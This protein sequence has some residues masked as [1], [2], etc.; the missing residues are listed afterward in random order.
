MLLSKECQN[1]IFLTQDFSNFFHSKSNKTKGTLVHEREQLT[2][3][4]VCFEYSFLARLKLFLR[5]RLNMYLE[6][7]LKARRLK[8]HR[9]KL[10]I[11]YMII[12]IL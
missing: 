2:L 3:L 6:K 9:L 11:D 12:F 7:G 1:V 8:G 5:P 4:M 10:M